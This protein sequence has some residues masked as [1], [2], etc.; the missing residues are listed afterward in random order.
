[1]PENLLGGLSPRQFLADYWHK[2]PLLIRQA[3]PDFRDL[4][5]RAELFE[6]ARDP[7]VES[8]HI[9]Q[10][11]GQWEVTRGQQKAAAL[12]GAKHPWTVLVQGLNLWLPAADELLHRFDFIPQARLDDLMVSYAVD[13]GGVGAHFDSY[14]VFLLQGKGKRR[15]RISDQCEHRL[16]E[17]APL[18]LVADFR[19]VE[20]W[21][22]E[23]G[24]MLYLPPRW[25]HEGTAIGECMTYS[26][27]FRAPAAQEIATEFLGWMQDRITL[28]G[29]YADPELSL[30]ANSAEIGDEML[31][32]VARMLTRISW[33]REDV[34][35]FLGHYL[36]D[37]KPQVFFDPP[38]TPLSKERFAMQLARHGFSLDAGTLLLFR[39]D[40][41]FLNG[42]VLEVAPQ[43]RAFVAALAHARRIDGAEAISRGA[44]ALLYQLYR[45]GFGHL[46][47]PADEG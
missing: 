38:N 26:I 36:T 30:Q 29:R 43:D 35:D 5:D 27:G 24:D 20:E 14:D 42:E 44:P 10:R 23:P 12:R 17:G 7:E 31:D 3:I 45:D 32:Q 22:L 13:G 6:L 2:K 8:R 37:P 34:R 21:V 19:P 15:W 25:A 4:L 18:K 1:M 16:V 40:S 11:D 28:E 33:D 46:E 9:R 47:C 39:G 41:F